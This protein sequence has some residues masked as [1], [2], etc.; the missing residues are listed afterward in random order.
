VSKTSYEDPARGR[1]AT[2]PWNMPWLGWR[3]TLQRVLGEFGRDNL[4]LVSAGVAFYFLFAVFPTLTAVLSVYGLIA[5]PSEAREI[6]ISVVNLLPRDA[7][8]VLE[9]QLTRVA[10][11]ENEGLTLGLVVS[12]ALS[13][14]FASRGVL[15]LMGGLNIAYEE[16]EDRGLLRL[17]LTGLG[18]LLVGLVPAILG[19]ALVAAL[20][21]LLLGLGI[22]TE[23]QLLVNVLRWPA[24]ATAFLGYVSLLY[25]F[26]PSRTSPQWSWLS[27]GA[28]L[29]TAL[30]LAASGLLGLYIDNFASYNKSYGSLAGVM[31]LLMWLWVTALSVLVG[32]ELN[33]ELERQTAE[34]TTKRPP[35]PMGERGAYVAD[36]LPQDEAPR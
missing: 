31:A 9:D 22:H 16:F 25:R 7:L 4:S 11:Q 28:V 24:L 1:R 3:E 29:A 18:L 8:G 21:L 17:N 30:W 26:G 27:A 34:D 2:Q 5:D 36:N 32:A 20:P 23:R 19:L 13:V 14:F 10:S 35:Q 12:L 6:V 33:A 15:A